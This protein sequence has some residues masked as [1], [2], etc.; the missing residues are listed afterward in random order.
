MMI[1]IIITNNKLKTIYKNQ[2]QKE[3]REIQLMN[4]QFSSK[5]N[6]LIFKDNKIIKQ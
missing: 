4:G 3:C 1:I 5:S 6:Y 2:R